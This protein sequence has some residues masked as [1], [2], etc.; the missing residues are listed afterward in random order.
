MGIRS[1]GIERIS[2][3]GE[4]GLAIASVTT[5]TIAASVNNDYYVRCP[6]SIWAIW[7]MRD[8]GGGA[9]PTLSSP[10]PALPTAFPMTY[11]AG[12]VVGVFGR[13]KHEGS[14][15]QKRWIEEY[16]MMDL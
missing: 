10:L 8:E 1:A 11:R 13:S 5:A 4:A 12:R 7:M 3:K 2:S 14:D 15:E 9:R 6:K 16:S